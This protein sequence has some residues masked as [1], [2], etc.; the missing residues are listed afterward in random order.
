MAAAHD[1]GPNLHIRDRRAESPFGAQ[2]Q[3]IAPPAPSGGSK[4]W[5]RHQA[6]N[7]HFGAQQSAPAS[8]RGIGPGLEIALETN[9]TYWAERTPVATRPT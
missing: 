5:I 4:S 8:K 7:A 6:S 2:D 9:F 1:P 3:R